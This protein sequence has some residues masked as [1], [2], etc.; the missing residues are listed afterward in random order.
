MDLITELTEQ[1]SKAPNNQKELFDLA[2]KWLN[3]Y[4]TVKGNKA[5]ERVALLCFKQC[6]YR[7]GMY[8][9]WVNKLNYSNL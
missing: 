5:K 9:Y 3:E 1:Q 7:L 6:M 2:I 8:D 4:L